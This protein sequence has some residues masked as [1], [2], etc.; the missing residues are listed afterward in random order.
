MSNTIA[1][2][3]TSGVTLS[4]VSD[5]PTTITSTGLLQ[6]GLN[7]TYTGN[8]QVLNQGTI[9]APSTYGIYLSGGGSVT[10]QAGGYIG[11]ASGGIAALGSALT[12]M[13][14]GGIYSSN[15]DAIHLFEGGSVTN[16]AVGTITGYTGIYGG[17]AAAASVV[18]DGVITGTVSYVAASF[19]SAGVALLDGGSITNQSGGLIVGYQGVYGGHAGAL[20]VV[21]AGTIAATY[22]A[23]AGAAFGNGVFLADG[24]T[25]VNQ[26]G[27]TITGGNGIATSYVP[28]TVVNDGDI[29]AINSTGVDMGAGGSLINQSNGV[30]TGY[31][32]VDS[33][34]YLTVVNAGTITGTEFGGISLLVGGGSVTNQAGG[35]ITGNDGVVGRESVTVINA[36]SIYGTGGGG[37]GVYLQGGGSVTNQSGGTITGD[38]GIVGGGTIAAYGL[39]PMTV[40]NAGSIA[41]TG[42]A[43]IRL[44]DGGTV[45]NQASGTISGYQGIYA[46]GELVTVVNYGVIAV[47]GS[48]A[49]ASF[50]DSGIALLAGGYVTNQSGGTIIG[51]DGIYGGSYGAL[52]VVNYG[53]IA[54]GAYG[55]GVILQSGGSV[56]N[57]AGGTITGYQGIAAGTV[58]ATVLNYGDIA[59]SGD[60]GVYLAGGGTIINQSSGTISGVFGVLDSNAAATVVNYGTIVGTQINGVVL[61]AGGGVTNQ[62]GGTITGGDGVLS[63]DFMTVV[64]AGSI[65]ATASYGSAVYFEGSGSVNNLSGGTI[66][67]YYGIKGA[68]SPVTVVN[69]GNISGNPYYQNGTGVLAVSGGYITNQ[70]GGTISGGV[71]I[72]GGPAGPMTVENAGTIVGS[73]YGISVGYASSITNVAGGT[74]GGYHAIV[75]YDTLTVVNDGTIAGYRGGIGLLGGGYVTNQSGGTIS[76]T[77]GIYSP[78]A[79]ITVVNAGSILGGSATTFMGGVVLLGGGT[80][81]NQT[82][83]TIAG[84]D[85]IYGGS[86]ASL[87]VVNAGSILGGTTGRY[88]GG[89]ILLGGGTIT[90]ETGGMIAGN[91]GI[92]GSGTVGLTVINAGSIGGYTY[93]AVLDAGGTINNQTGG[94]ISGGLAAIVASN[95][96]I[97]V[98][99]YGRIAAYGTAGRAIYL[100]AGGSVANQA[101]GTISGY[102]GIDSML[103]GMTVVNA[104]SIIGTGGTA[105]QFAAGYAN[106]LTI[107]PGAV[108]TGTVD[109]GN[110]IGATAVSTLELAQGGSPGM[111]SG[112]GTQFIDFGQTTIDSGAYWVLGGSNALAAGTTLT[113]FGTLAVTGATFFDAGQVTNDGTIVIDPSDVTFG[114]LTGTGDVS[115]DSGSTLNVIGTV[116]SS[117][118]IIFS[119]TND[120]LGANPT[121]F[122]GQINGFTFGDTIDL[123][124]VTDAISAEIVNGNTLQID[125]SGNSPVDLTLDPSVD[126]TGDAY[127]VGPTG[128]VTEVVPCFVPGTL[129]RTERGDV[130]VELLEAGDR[131]VTLSGSL[132][133]IRWIGRRDLVLTRHPTPCR[134]QPVAIRAHAF[135]EGAPSRDLFLSPEHAVL[136]DGGLVPVRL[137]VNGASIQRDRG[138]RRVSYYHVELES[139]DILLAENL[140]VESYLETGNRG[141]F[142][143]ADG[144]LLLHPDLSSD[145]TR[146]MAASCAP[147]FDDPARV[148]PMWRALA[149]R[150]TRCGWALPTARPTTEDPALCLM[151]DGRRIAPVSVS[152]GKHVFTIPNGASVVRL[153]SHRAVP[154]DLAP[155]VADDRGLGVM[156]R[157][158]TV[159]SGGDAVPI[160]LDHPGL[161]DGWWQAEWHGPAIL[162]RWT[163][164]DALVP[165]P[166]RTAGVCLLEVEVAATLAYPVAAT[167]PEP[168]SIRRCA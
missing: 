1:T 51:Y 113:N 164:G 135:G 48:A 53:S 49:T 90:N 45:V 102:L 82:S 58:A 166:A 100:N 142:E 137:L 43:G 154:S 50:Y 140:P 116:T 5:D 72:Y 93:G 8:W 145:Q 26:A 23:S 80:V 91:D 123:A 107:D 7:V 19:A 16:Q 97:A 30:I 79:S 31:F 66:A 144:P 41:G 114:S 4:S 17:P 155:W 129:I 127:A 27:G 150:A 87:T 61:F 136:V 160:P 138:R 65:V 139:H 40:V 18:N 151:V 64:N 56:T 143:N 9:Q 130:A 124:G 12:V 76:G 128:A 22:F 120:L 118:T 75:A 74:I 70:A 2:T 32:G 83:G 81:T 85:A 152:Q 59:A 162:R 132:R 84:Y 89:V 3:Y 167:A 68:V 108:F 46:A 21:N 104:G 60:V 39:G 36:G 146:R 122:A 14:Y 149:E 6:Q 29:T 159:R 96:A 37:V 95:T 38:S 148:E 11:G 111:L 121:A 163:N 28:A 34:A 55:D 131:V 78:D 57:Q 147:F 73:G 168:L 94:T 13:N 77:V 103:A 69:A 158:L 63:L 15:S 88:A 52:T 156:L 165:M 62:A 105:A 54:A 47:T 134:V 157:G 101:G 67:G 109:G 33:A 119:G 110:T 20:T 161:G 112:I 44:D 10:N 153:R 133:P 125:R 92:Y 141:M 126:Y 35:T 115:I 25:I 42:S 106:L 98:N 71:G 99:N 117:E 86:Y 24:G